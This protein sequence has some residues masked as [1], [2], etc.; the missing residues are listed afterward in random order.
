MKIIHGI[1]NIKRKFKSPVVAIGVFDGLHRGH[2]QLI[3]QAIQEA[4]QIRGTA[5]VMTFWPHPAHVLRPEI[6]L[7]LLVSLPHRLRL[8]EGLGVDV[9]IVIPFT[10]SFSRLSPEEFVKNY[11]IRNIKPVEIFVGYD[12][13]F[14]KNR[15]GDLNRFKTIS[16][17]LGF[18]INVLHAIKG[19][20]RAISSTL[21]R[22][23]VIQGK[24]S[25]ASRL[26]GRFVSLMGTVYR[27]DAR[28]RLLGF[29]TAN[30]DPDGELIPPCGVYAVSVLIGN[31]RYG[32]MANI[33]YR[34][35]F[36][37]G[38]KISIE[39]HIFHF[40]KKIYSRTILVE[41]IKKIRDERMFLFKG[42]LIQQ[43]YEDEIKAKA[44]IAKS[45]SSRN[46]SR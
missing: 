19:G 23:L 25:Q 38:N 35:S 45:I 27:G 3:N 46:F 7:P 16:K 17:E 10:K 5:I 11:L 4:R 14:G 1:K 29:P 42:Q 6:R 9:C 15:Q 32:G 40:R 34:P 28:G 41:F 21:I 2:Q 24:L 31:K 22:E 18:K 13:R 8:L 37:N 20:A 12:F 43:L 26:L 36:K 44:I 39:V 30:V 33:G